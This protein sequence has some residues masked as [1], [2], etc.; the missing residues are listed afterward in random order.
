MGFIK[1][2]EEQQAVPHTGKALGRKLCVYERIQRLELRK[3]KGPIEWYIRAFQH[4][5][6]FLFV[7]DGGD[8]DLS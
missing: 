3:M 5:W 6:E 1:L 4:L 2:Q 7:E 8:V